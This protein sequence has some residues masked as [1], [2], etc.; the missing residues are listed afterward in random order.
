MEKRIQ[1]GVSILLIYVL[2]IV[3]TFYMTNRIERLDAYQE[4]EDIALSLS[5]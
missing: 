4:K 2:L 1:K 3:F 5:K